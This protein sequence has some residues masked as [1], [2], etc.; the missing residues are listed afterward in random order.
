M[1]P[2]YSSRTTNLIKLRRHV[3]QTFLLLFG[4]LRRA[5]HTFMV[6]AAIVIGVLGAFG[7]I[8]FRFLIRTG[9][10]LLFTGGI[11]PVSGFGDMAWWTILCVPVIGGLLVGPIAHFFAREVRGS[12]IPEVMESV[13]V[14]GGSIRPRVVVAKA[15][16][17]AIT[18]G[19]GGSAGREGPIVQIVTVHG[20]KSL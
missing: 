1:N 11:E 20:P 15:I 19:S 10:S 3:S 18:I 14:W 13:A 5:E 17:A 6:V 9:Q 16:A 4:K 2:R 8:A 12:G 7:A